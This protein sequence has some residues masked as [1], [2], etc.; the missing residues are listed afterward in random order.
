[1]ARKKFSLDFDE[2]LD[3]AYD[4]SEQYGDEKLLEATKYALEASRDYVNTKVGKAMKD[5]K[6]SFKAGEGYSQGE[7][8]KSLVEVS[9]M[10]VEVNGTVVTAYAGIDLKQAPEA[11]ILAVEG[12]PHE[13]PDLQLRHALQVKGK[14]RKGVD[15]IQEKMFMDVLEGKL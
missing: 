13:S 12:S 2:F 8:R 11:L 3:L 1:M 7:A 9:R 15:N 4:I 14:V 5:S 10:P 6:F